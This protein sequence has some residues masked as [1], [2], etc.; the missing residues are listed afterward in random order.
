[1]PT[2]SS[3]KYQ[4]KSALKV[5]SYNY[6]MSIRLPKWWTGKIVKIEGRYR[7]IQLHDPGDGH[8]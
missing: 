4:I 7:P 5:L 8:D 3:K 2:K 6:P 1:M